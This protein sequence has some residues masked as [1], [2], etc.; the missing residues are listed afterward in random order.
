M[1]AVRVKSANHCHHC[2]FSLRSQFCING[3]QAL[4]RTV[5]E[6]AEAP[7]PFIPGEIEPL[8]Q[9]AFFCTF[10]HIFVQVYLEPKLAFA[11]VLVRIADSSRCE[12]PVGLDFKSITSAGTHERCSPQ[13]TTRVTVPQNGLLGICTL[14]SQNGASFSLLMHPTG[15]RKPKLVSNLWEVALGC[16]SP[17]LGSKVS[18]K[19]QCEGQS[20]P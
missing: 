1:I 2:R 5:L 4:T 12:G 10:H 3:S 16:P 17:A 18:K 14:L 8:P 15:F 20:P 9:D 7:T 11:A 19:G 6:A 13:L